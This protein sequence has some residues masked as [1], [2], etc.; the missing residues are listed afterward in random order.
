MGSEMCI[1]D[2]AWD[3]APGWLLHTE[4]GGY[5]R[6]LDGTRYLVGKPGETGILLAT[7]PEAWDVLQAPIQ[8]AIANFK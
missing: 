3:H 2:R 5:S 4:A 8:N 6:C 7:D 1:R